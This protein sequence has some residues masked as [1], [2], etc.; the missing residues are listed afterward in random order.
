[1][2]SGQVTGNWHSVLSTSYSVRFI[3]SRHVG[4][5]S[6]T[7][8]GGGAFA[9]RTRKC[10]TGLSLRRRRR[11]AVSVSASGATRRSRLARINV[12]GT[13][14]APSADGI[15]RP[16]GTRLVLPFVRATCLVEFAMLSHLRDS[17]SAI[18]PNP[19][20]PRTADQTIA[21]LPRA[22]GSMTPFGNQACGFQPRLG[23]ELNLRQSV[24]KTDALTTELPW[25]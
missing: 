6:K 5:S 7:P 12:P 25:W 11:R 22:S 24:S 13:V 14:S 21:R 20:P 23:Q 17:R 18:E 15:R 9:D 16:H 1:M 10:G 19:S 4:P 3:R 8:L 2:V